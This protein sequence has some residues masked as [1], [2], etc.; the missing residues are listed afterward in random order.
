MKRLKN[1]YAN[2]MSK[3]AKTRLLTFIKECAA[4][5]GKNDGKKVIIENYLTQNGIAQIICT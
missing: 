4:K 1:N 2:L 3:D 5:E